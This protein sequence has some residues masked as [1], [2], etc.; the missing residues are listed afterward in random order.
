METQTEVLQHVPPDA[1]LADDNSRFGLKK[2]RLELMMES[3]MT[4]GEIHTPLDVEELDVPVDGKKFRIVDGHYRHGAAT[5]LTKNGTVILCPIRVNA[6]MDPAI[7]LKRQVSFNVQRENPSPMDMAVAIKKLLDAGV[8]RME[9]R[10]I[11]AKSG[12]RK[13]EKVAPLS[14]SYLNMMMSFLDFPKA[15]QNLVHAGVIG[16]LGAY[17]LT[18]KPREKWEEIVAECVKDY[19]AQEEREAKDEEKYLADIK[20]REEE[21]QKLKQLAI[22]AEA[23]KAKL[24]EL[25]AK[26]DVAAKTEGDA[27]VLTRTAKAKEEKEK[28]AE[29]LAKAKEE[30][31]VAIDA[32]AEAKKEADKLEAKLAKVKEAAEE[33]AKKLE[34]A[35]KDAAKK[36]KGEEKQEGKKKGIGKGEIDRASGKLGVGNL[37]PLNATQMRAAVDEWSLPGSFPKVAALATIV[38]RVFA[39]ELTPGQGYTEMGKITGEKVAKKKVE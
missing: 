16:V 17:T 19:E 20:K 27:T 6:P 11:Y 5:A 12:G 34:Q 22:D 1:L 35:R 33:R 38:K 25:S 7:R 24:Q 29:A 37:V 3:I 26:V 21:D 28:A 15:V 30:T 14:N 31:K 13:G 18:R 4:M 23:A 36:A 8:P 10:T 32:A 39:S 9:I 2:P